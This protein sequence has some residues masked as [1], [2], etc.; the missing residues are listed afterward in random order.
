MEIV[1]IELHDH[2]TD[3]RRLDVEVI[4]LAVHCVAEVMIDVDDGAGQ[5][6]IARPLHFRAFHREHRVVRIGIVGGQRVSHGHIRRAGN[7]VQ[8]AIEAVAHLHLRLFAHGTEQTL[9][10]E[11]AAQRVAVGIAMRGDEEIAPFADAL[12]GG[13]GGGIKLIRCHCLST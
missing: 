13:R 10:S 3:R 1:A 2:L 5:N 11:T 12:G 7:V 8:R 9:K 6:R 4:D